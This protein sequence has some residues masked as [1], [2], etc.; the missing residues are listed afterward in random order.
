MI[1]MKHLLRIQIQSLRNRLRTMTF[2]GDVKT[3]VLLLVGILF[4]AVIYFGSWRLVGYLNGVPVAGPLLINKLL[5]L[6]FLTAFSMVV[7][8]G[9]VT[10]FSALFFSKDL[11]WLMATPLPVRTLFTFKAF[12]TAVYSS[13][14]VLVAILPFL[15]AV[16][17][18]KG[19]GSWFYAGTGVLLFPFLFLSG[20][21]GILAT[22]LLMRFFPSRRTRDLLVLLGILCTTG[23]YVLFR[24]LQPERFVKPDGFEV[25]AQYLAYLNAPTA[26]FLPSWWITGG[27]YSLIAGTRG[28]FLFYAALLY[29]AA[30]AALLAVVFLAEKFFY[31]GWA[32][33]QVYHRPAKPAVQRYIRRPAFIALL[34]KDM[35]VFFRDV[36]Q[37]SQLLVLGALVLV[38][39]FSIYKLPLDTF[40]LQNLVAFF[41][42]GLIGFILAAVALRFVFPSISLEGE[43]WWFL[44]AA[45]LTPARFLLEKLVFGSLP[46]AVLGILLVIASNVLLK[47][48]RPIFLL[49]CTAVAIMTL[50]INAMAIGFGALFPRFRYDNVAQVEASAGG[51]F[52]MVSALF[53]LCLSLSLWAPAVHNFYQQKLGGLH[54]PWQQLWW[55]GAGL[56]IVNM[57]AIALPLWFGL[58]SLE[59]L[60]Q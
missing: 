1:H 9:V 31:F 38:Y 57:F 16:G 2:A 4:L 32:E 26:S 21:A 43:S 41:N 33:G 28:G 23:V 58:R 56:L 12:T 52:F 60:E 39:L 59:V 25:V 35:A 14:M 34:R 42:I 3:A 50:G 7:F 40:A 20:M 54:L 51:L 46:G 48:D 17:Q 49:S 47:T 10:S 15:F 22:L 18:V 36:T 45:P 27:M 37:W 30:A 6:V 29:G 44:R 13:W 5:A 55:V 8:S 19:A 24:L 53:Y 11:K